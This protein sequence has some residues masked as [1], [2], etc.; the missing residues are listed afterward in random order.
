MSVEELRAS[1]TKAIERDKPHDAIHALVQL[2]RLEPNE[3]R[4]AQ[5]LGES[6][7][8]VGD[9]KCAVDAFARAFERYFARG[10]VPRAIAMA[11]L[12]KSLDAARGDLL[13]RS[14]PRDAPMPPPLPRARPM[15]ERPPLH[16]DPR[17]EHLVALRPPPLPDKN[18]V[19]PLAPPLPAA[20]GPKP[21]RSSG[22]MAKIAP[23]PP[24]PPP[25]SYR[26]APLPDTFRISRPAP[27]SLAPDSS[28]DEI[29]FEDAPEASIEILLVELETS[30]VV[31]I[32][33]DD[34]D[35]EVV[36]DTRPV[37]PSILSTR[38]RNPDFD[39]YTSLATVRLFAAL[40]RDALIA[41]ADAAELVEFVPGAM[42]IVRDERAFALYSIVSG[43]ACVVVPGSPEIRLREG[44]IFGEA[45]LLEEGKRQA[46]VK[47]ETPL[48]ALRVEKSALA[49]VMKEHPELEDA[50]FDLMA[51]RLVMNLMHSSPIFAAFDPQGRLE[52][53][54]KFEVRRA[55]AG[56]VIAE[57]GRRSD[58]LYVLLAGHVMAEP[59]EG[60]PTRIARG[61]AFGHASLLGS[62]SNLTI[63]CITESV[64][65]RMPA[66]GFSV[67][68]ALYPPVLAY[69]AE[70][71][72]EP[73]PVSRRDP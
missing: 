41:L 36:S 21:A 2:E 69:L 13:E 19:K 71:A 38:R 42:I 29:R 44:D 43:S 31:N 22:E 8:R 45:S 62:G 20:K 1:W 23:P 35:V 32:E 9:T 10:F 6:Y 51:R 50:L 66:A 47:A 25:D 55:A 24:P 16:N 34:S 65:L 57:R 53:A 37:E 17:A 39:A 7:R 30:E 27:L 48:M 64:I 67:L 52:L 73:L 28:G 26:Q 54:Q 18:L 46:D 56:T 40:S 4:W 58:G 14:L 15:T 49:P 72:N 33:V 70:T 63:R 11:K 68:A 3:P 12:V 59:A 60:K 5:R 61:T